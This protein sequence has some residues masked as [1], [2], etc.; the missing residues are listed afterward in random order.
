MAIGEL[1]Y[2]LWTAG[3]L[4]AAPAGAAGP[5]ALQINGDWVG[6]ANAWQELGCPYEQALALADSNEPADLLT[7]LGIVNRLGARPIADLLASRLRD[8]GVTRLPR[9]PRRGTI[10]NPAGLTDR[11]LEVLGLL[12]ASLTDAEVSARLHITRKTAGHH[13]SAILDKLGVHS[14]HAAAQVARDLGLPVGVDDREI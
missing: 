13:V 14:R 7:A 11:E 6:A 2:W 10:E 8:L 5:Y 3:A 12:T 4:A 1:A 9:R